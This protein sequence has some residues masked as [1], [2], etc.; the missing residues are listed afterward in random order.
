MRTAPLPANEAQRLAALRE[1]RILD[2]PPDPAYDEIARLASQICGVP[3]ALIALTDQDR[4]W[5]KARVGIELEETPRNLAFCAHAIL[6]PDLLLVPDAT[7]DERF[8]DNPFVTSAPNVRFYAGA[9][10]RT[11]G[12][13]ALGTLCVVDQVPRELSEEQKAA[14]RT[15]A[16]QVVTRMELDRRL[17]ELQ[18]VVDAQS[19][20]DQQLRRDAAFVELLQQ[21]A[22]AANEA[23]GVEQAMQTCLD[24]VCAITEWPAGH[25]YFLSTDGTGELVPGNIWNADRPGY[26]QPL[27]D[28][29][30]MTR[31]EPGKGLPGRVLQSG[32]A[33]WVE[34]TREELE[35]PRAAAIQSSGLHSAFGFPILVG[36][37]VAAVLEFYT[38]DPSRP[39]DR[40]FRVMEQIGTQMG[41]VIER[42]WAETALRESSAMLRSFYDSSDIQ[43]GVVELLHNDLMFV[44]TNNAVAEFFH[45]RPTELRW[46]LLSELGV[47]REALERW[48]GFYRSASLSGKVER[49]EVQEQ[50]EGRELWFEIAICPIREAS[51]VNPR[52]AFTVEDVTQRKESEAAVLEGA[53]ML[54]SFYD[55]A[56]LMMGVVEL[57]DDDIVYL[58]SNNATERV[59]GL[60][61][62]QMKN[63]RA[64][65]LRLPRRDIQMWLDRY[66]ESGRTDAPVRFEYR[67]R[68][69]G[70]RRWYAATVCPVRG[71]SAERPRYAYVVEDIT[72]RKQSEAALRDSEE[73]FR[74]SFEHAP[75]G[76][77]LV[78]LDGC[79]LQVNRALCEIVGYPDVELLTK[80]FQDITHPEDLEADLALVRQVLAGKISE[81]QMEKRYLHRDG[82]EVPILLSVSLV[83]GGD[84]EPLYFIAQIQD[85]TERRR[86]E[87]ELRAAKEAAES[88]NRA[89]SDFLAS[90]SHEIRTPMNAI[91]GMA[92]LLAETPLSREQGDYV[93]VFKRAGETLLTLINDIL[94]LS[95]IESGHME[96]ERVEFDVVEVA[97]KAT[98][99]LAVRA[100]EKGLELLCHVDPTFASLRLG[101]PN[102]LRQV[103]L[104]LLGNAIKFTELGE[105]V[106]DVRSTNPDDPDAPLHFSVRDTGIGIP[107]EK[108]ALIFGKFTQADSSTTRRYGGSG[109]GLAIS[110][111]LV[112][113]MDGEMWV[114]SVEGEGSTFHFTAR[115]PLGTRRAVASP[116]WSS[117]SLENVRTL[118]VDDNGTNRYILTELL[119]RWG[120]RVTEATG[121]PEALAALE[122]GKQASDPYRLLLV[123]KRMPGMDGFQLVDTLNRRGDFSGLL[124]LMITSDAR[125][126]D[127][128][129]AR[130]IGLARYLIKPVKQ[131]DL[132]EAVIAALEKSPGPANTASDVRPTSPGEASR[133]CRILLVED[134]ADNR[135]LILA[136]LRK[137][138]HQVEIAENGLV[139]V[140]KFQ[141][142]P[143]DLV[144]MDMQMPV[145]DGYAAT[146]EIRRWETAHGRPPV[147]IIALT[148]HAL[149]EHA[150][151]ST[152]AGC[153]AHVTKPIKKAILLETVEKY[154]G[155][156]P[157]P[158]GDGPAEGKNDRHV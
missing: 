118:V 133:G 126:G 122:A 71:T 61:P 116:Q 43:M 109:L 39:D 53:A 103:L 139:A 155:E 49:F 8:A 48:M 82:H 36:R 20:A 83:R 86:A 28:A 146:R 44:T 151:L 75:I 115:L 16:D 141:A 140:Q 125:G 24:R 10:L 81:Y 13:T 137:T 149:P 1:Y 29:T 33:E 78:A 12:G 130:E 135:A 31:L 98:E 134:A 60:T 14:L 69:P 88:A 111:Q 17:R 32:K 104:N 158:S 147:P 119:T 79:W 108:R 18:S 70:Y 91:I 21:I 97:E 154:A 7:K 41:R 92:D 105:V 26:A 145:M 64:S 4:Q 113:L 72:H 45:V 121:G 94:D 102:R 84:A 52:F 27:V 35:F 120:A 65:E 62:E 46:K 101:D 107:E 112:E 153:T 74:S 6:Q 85:I 50:I 59:Y 5:F 156:Q 73:R 67:Y 148:A 114:E 95:K 143:F 40:V 87:V 63:R 90:M 110:R 19:R 42:N 144:L 58:S 2:T 138:P 23:V 157:G 3:I 132:R 89:K 77:A 54:R 47:P 127:I 152:D 93:R 56:D 124:I 30:A 150:V 51:T 136:Y 15:L 11:S 76:I 68:V 22:V 129:R 123:D 80:T 131:A 55:S 34:E 106:L 9:P 96:L 100:H 66:G 128:T 57:V 142:E 99:V 38:A 117:N 25:V 37:Q